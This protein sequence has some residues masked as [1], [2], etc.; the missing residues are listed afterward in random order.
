MNAPL[1]TVVIPTYNRARLLSRA[2]WSVLSQEHRPLELVIV[3]D[4]STDDTRTMIERLSSTLDALGATCRYFYQEQ[5]GPAAARNVGIS[6]ATGDYV[7]FLDSDDVWYP[8]FVST[9]LQLLRTYPDA[10]LAFCSSESMKADWRPQGRREDGLPKNVPHGLLGSPEVQ[11]LRRMPIVT[12]AVLLPRDAIRR[13]GMFDERLSVGEDWDLWFRLARLV[14]FAF[15]REIHV[16]C[17]R[18]HGN[19]VQAAVAPLCDKVLLNLKHAQLT[20]NSVARQIYLS[21]AGNY[22]ALAL[23][24]AMRDGVRPATVGPALEDPRLP[25]SLR[26]RLA[27]WMYARPSALG[28][29]Y[30]RGIRSL[31]NLL[32]CEMRHVGAFGL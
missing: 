10:G 14:P 24:H 18:H 30:A 28:K 3:D 19:T 8:R 21:R 22:A 32:R 25:R 31:G 23:E 6:H 7:S 26:L 9:L 16:C 15:T 13:V 12:P 20:D 17:L 1:V 2:I 27:R 5:S 29:A 4:G 11:I